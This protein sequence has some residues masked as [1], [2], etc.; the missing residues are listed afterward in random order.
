VIPVLRSYPEGFAAAIVADQLWAKQ[1]ERDS[2]KQAIAA[3]VVP[4]VE[5]PVVAAPAA[6][7]PV[8]APVVAPETTGSKKR[9]KDAAPEQVLEAKAS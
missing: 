2:K 7:Q 8:E 9:K 6:V 3:A 4:P 1:Q 5:V